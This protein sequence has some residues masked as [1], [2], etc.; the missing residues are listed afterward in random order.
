[1]ESVT[2]LLA[3]GEAT[4]VAVR[5]K[6]KVSP[7]SG[8]AAA[9]WRWVVVAG[10]MAAIFTVS[11]GP[12][13][14]LPPGLSWDKVL[15]AGAYAVMTG[16]VVWAM[17]RGRLRDATGRA[18]LAGVLVAAAYGATDELHQAFV[19]GRQSD[20]FDFLADA[21]GALAAAGAIRAWGIIA[22]GSE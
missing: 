19:P 3:K 16:L 17:T 4:G 10:Y 20:V 2:F 7:F 8:R 22:R 15:H 11:G 13:P 12:G 9:W 1:M 6:R 18:L 5:V 21:I 14:E